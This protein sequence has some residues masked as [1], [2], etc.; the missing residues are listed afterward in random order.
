MAT[1][2]LLLRLFRWEDMHNR[3]PWWAFMGRFVTFFPAR[4]WLMDGLRVGHF[5]SSLFRRFA[6]HSSTSAPYCI[7]LQ[8][9][10]GPLFLPLVV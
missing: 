1:M 10:L 4:L 6:S 8:N 2:V 7:R 3:A 9:Y 5:T